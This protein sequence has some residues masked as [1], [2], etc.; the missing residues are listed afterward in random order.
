MRALNRFLLLGAA[1]VA[2]A[3]AF[4]QTV[5]G[6]TPEQIEDAKRA[7]MNRRAADDERRMASWELSMAG[8]RRP[9]ERRRDAT[10]AYNQIREDYKQIQIVNNDLARN[11]ATSG[12]LDF[13]YITK[14]VSDIKARALRLKENLV[15]PEDKKPVE[16]PKLEVAA[17]AVR[18]KNA[19]VVLDNLVMQFVNSPIFEQAKA[20]NVEQATKARRGLEEIIELSDQIKKCVEKM[21]STAQKTP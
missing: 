9:P 19:L 6:Q 21:K 5:Y 18:L 10:L 12:A 11:V 8:V 4:S 16:R 20:V 17:E 7:E 2:L 15:L 14:S 1:V 13:K 3:S